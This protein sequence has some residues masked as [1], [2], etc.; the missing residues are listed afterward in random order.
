MEKANKSMV[1]GIIG[2]CLVGVSF[3]VF[4]FLSLPGFILGI[5]A[6]TAHLGDKK[7]GGK[8]SI[9]GFVCGLLALIL[10]ALAFVLY[11]IAVIQLAQVAAGTMIALF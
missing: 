11:I 8:G 2:I 6:V 3:F 4:G 5:L 1:L 9:A 10:G 7:E